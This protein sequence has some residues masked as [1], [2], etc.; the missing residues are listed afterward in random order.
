MLLY[1]GQKFAVDK[2]ADKFIS[3]DQTTTNPLVPAPTKY[4]TICDDNTFDIF[5]DKYGYVDDTFV[6]I[7]WP[8]VIADFGGFYLGDVSFDKFFKT[9][10]KDQMLISWWDL[11][12]YHDGFIKWAK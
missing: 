3:Y 8:Q 1:K 10:Y 2:V 7:E 5:T 6:R 9:L 4:L 12:Y 11:E